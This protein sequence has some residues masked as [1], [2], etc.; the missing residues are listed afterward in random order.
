MP[1]INWKSKIQCFPFHTWGMWETI[2]EGDILRPNPFTGCKHN[3][4]T[5]KTQQ[6]TCT[7]CGKLQLRT[8]KTTILT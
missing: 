6:R 5:F 7:G 4:G 3:V 1:V 2:E 8:V